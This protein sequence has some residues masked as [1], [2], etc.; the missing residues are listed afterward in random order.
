[1]KDRAPQEPNTELLLFA[2]K[3]RL[4][5]KSIAFLLFIAMMLHGDKVCKNTK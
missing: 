2:I 5:N 1:M 3:L 4:K